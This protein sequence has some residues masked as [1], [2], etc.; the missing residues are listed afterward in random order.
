MKFGHLIKFSLL[1]SIFICGF[2]SQLNV[3]S[4]YDLTQTMKQMFPKNGS[5]IN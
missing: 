4:P 2:N 5:K 1:I 3:M